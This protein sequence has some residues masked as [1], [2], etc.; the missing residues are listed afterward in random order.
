MRRRT[1][2]LFELM[3][4]IAVL[5]TLAALAL[6]S[7]YNAQLKAKVAEVPLNVDGIVAAE[8]AYLSAHDRVVFYNVDNP[9]GLPS[10]TR[11][12]WDPTT[13]LAATGYRP[14]G[15]VYGSYSTRDPGVPGVV[16]R[17]G[18]KT[19]VDADFNFAYTDADIGGETNTWC[20]IS[21][22]CF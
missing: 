11:R 18:A 15:D 1:F 14:D 7:L 17:V 12:P 13:P 20:G 21:D 9:A 22:P 6:P 2:S 19:D 8:L 3:V 10:K 16:L 4:V 5:V